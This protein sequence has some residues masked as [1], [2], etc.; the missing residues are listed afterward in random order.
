MGT[1][2]CWGNPNYS[3]L[4]KELHETLLYFRIKFNISKQEL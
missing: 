1:R 2:I 3:Y 4:N